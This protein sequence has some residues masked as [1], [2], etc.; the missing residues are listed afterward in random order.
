MANTL[1]YNLSKPDKGATNWHLNVNNNMDIIDTELKNI[2]D[3][4]ANALNSD[5]I[6]NN[7]E[8]EEVGKVLDAT[9]GKILD[10]KIGILNTNLNLHLSDKATPL[11]K[12]GL[13][14]SNTAEDNDTAWAA[15]MASTDTYFLLGEGTYKT[16]T[17]WKLKEGATLICHPLAVI[18]AIENVNI[19]ELSDK[20][21]LIGSPTLI[22]NV[23]GFDKAAL[24]INGANHITRLNVSGIPYCLTNHTG[25]GVHVDCSADGS[26]V[27]FAEINFYAR[28]NET[29]LLLEGKIGQGYPNSNHFNGICN[30]NRTNVK[31]LNNGS[32]NRFDI[33]TQADLAIDNR[34]DVYCDGSYNLFNITNIDVG[35][36]THTK[37]L[38][39]FSKLSVG[40]VFTCPRAILYPSQY[41]EDYGLNN[42]YP[43]KTPVSAL[44][45]YPYTHSAPYNVQMLGNQDDVLAFANFKHTVTKTGA[46]GIVSQDNLFKPDGSEAIF[47][48]R[49]QGV[50]CKLSIVLSTPVSYPRV[51]GLCFSSVARAPY[52]KFRVKSAI[53]NTW[54]EK[55]F[56]NTLSSQLDFVTWD[57]NDDATAIDINLRRISEIEIILDHPTYEASVYVSRIFLAASAQGNAWVS[58]DGGDIYGDMTFNLSKGVIVRTPD[59]TKRYRIGVDNAGAITTTLVT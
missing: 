45:G 18:E 19:L 2:S 44:N 37:K 13:S 57:L 6:I 58:R 41:I 5:D 28:Y 22:S 10:D 56:D 23:E 9:Q 33:I 26:F 53:N 30:G 50:G 54:Y 31:V 7:L 25:K 4:I 36:A 21:Q 27:Y 59:G 55:V 24:Y 17:G 52:I 34:A 12:F 32:M 39:T 11:K 3:S 35:N 20:C 51:L 43:G 29:G 47:V 46:S 49:D 1:N 15:A 38:V 14:P 48:M 42:S 8:Q 40:N 16:N